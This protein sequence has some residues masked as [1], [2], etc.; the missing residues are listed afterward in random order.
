MT[1]I[2]ANSLGWISPK[3]C[4]DLLPRWGKLCRKQLQDWTRV[5]RAGP[6]TILFKNWI[7]KQ[8]HYWS[9]P[10]TLRCFPVPGNISGAPVSLGITQFIQSSTRLN[11][12]YLHSPAFIFKKQHGSA[13]NLSS[14]LC[15]ELC[16][17]KSLSAWP[18]FTQRV[19]LQT[20]SCWSFLC[21]WPV[22]G[23]PSQV[24]SLHI[25]P[26]IPTRKAQTSPPLGS[27]PW[28]PPPRPPSSTL[29]NLKNT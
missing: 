11:G 7:P 13:A 2:F 16:L 25:F 3:M 9:H 1:V 4:S 14:F 19:I 18:K 8:S 12:T 23:H 5:P 15:V 28:R 17:D 29:N 26:L 24:F 20:R 27:P 22:L 21:V 6:T 10:L